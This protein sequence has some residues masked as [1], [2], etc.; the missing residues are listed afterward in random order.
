MIDAGSLIAVGLAGFL[1]GMSYA[2]RGSLAALRDVAHARAILVDGR[3]YVLMPLHPDAKPART[4]ED[5]SR[6]VE[7]EAG[8]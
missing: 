3:A 8:L 6:E 7:A 1:A 2:S 5:V 4:L